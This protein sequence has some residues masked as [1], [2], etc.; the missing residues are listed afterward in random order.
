MTFKTPTHSKV[1]KL[2][3]FNHL[4]D[5]PVATYATDPNVYVGF[6]VE[7][8]II[9]QLVNF[10]PIDRHSGFVTFLDGADRF[11]VLLNL[12]VTVH[13]SLARRNRGK[14]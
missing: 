12:F 2:F 5:A 13:A 8:N 1:G 4:I 11:A 6:V 9:R 3:H 10:Q 7:I 14:R